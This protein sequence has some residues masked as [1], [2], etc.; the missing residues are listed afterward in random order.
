[1]GEVYRARDPRLER[2]VALKVILGDAEPSL[3]QRRRLEDEA[4]AASA[5]SHP[6]ILSVF[7]VLFDREPPCVVFELLE[8]E[9]LRQRLGPGPLPWRR[10][11]EY[12]T[13]IGQGLAAAHAK[14]I[15]HRD[16]KPENLFVTRDGRVKILDF[17]LAK[18]TQVL[19]HGRNE[20]SENPTRTATQP[21]TLLGTLAYMSPEQARG[22][23][24]DA[25]S[26]IFAL[27]ATLYEMLSGRSAFHRPSAAETLSAVLG[28]DPESLAPPSAVGAVPLG[29]EQIVRRCLEKEPDERFQSARDVSFALS[30]LFASARSDES[31]TAMAP[32]HKRS[33]RPFW[34]AV[35]ALGTLGAAL[36]LGR[37]PRESAG[38]SF[39]RLTFR[40]GDVRT[41][42]F[43]ADGQTIVYGASWDGEPFRLFT[44]RVEQIESRPLDLPA[45]DVL[46]I[47]PQ[48][49]MA[50][51]IGRTR[52]APFVSAGTLARV[53]LA[54]GAPREILE[55]V[56]GADWTPDGRELAVLHRFGGRTRLE[57]P[58]KK[59]LHEGW[60]LGVRVSPRGDVLALRDPEGV[61]LV[62]RDGK[63]RFLAPD[64]GGL[65]ISVAWSPHGDAVW[66]TA[67]EQGTD[68]ELRSVDL[69]GR[70]LRR[71]GLPLFAEVVDVNREGRALVIAGEL[72][73]GIAALPPGEARERDLSWLN[74]SR[75][76]DLS[77]DGRTLL[78]G[79]MGAGR[80]S[81]IYLRRTDGSPAVRLGDGAPAALSPDSKWVLTFTEGT[82][83]E[84]RIIPSGAGESRTRRF[85]E[86]E[87]CGSGRF[88][89]S[90]ER[91]LVDAHA[92][93]EAC[94]AYVVDLEP[95]IP[96]RSLTPPGLTGDAISP[97]GSWV[98]TRGPEGRIRLFPVAGGAP[99]VV[100][101]PPE[102]G[103]IG[104]FSADGRALYVTE[105]PGPVARIFRRDLETGHREI[106]KELSPADP[107]GLFDLSP[108]A[109]AD[110]RS[111]VY[112]HTGFRGSLY[113]LDGLD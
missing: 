3:E 104:P 100:P 48:S 19:G 62:D 109:A 80:K 1:M 59:V 26:D 98:A 79:E 113:L 36:L 75:A 55:D 42:R 14:G 27:G 32:P 5:L 107:A 73:T 91:L 30:A 41:A 61:W 96:P 78:F 87:A 25:R 21:G 103:R 47:S 7:D 22:G 51:C 56:M 57:F 101:G 4:R 81:A 31:A 17:G 46:A 45:G 84:L 50:I 12:A 39:H 52:A 99:R 94:R 89:P 85:E 82:P 9:T 93:G 102:P 108:I 11:V 105:V 38:L 6:N 74:V 28:H 16:L 58:I 110:G 70:I 90:G 34:L 20:T 13:Q 97:D 40:R 77:P 10:A 8:G 95:G 49:E 76:V 29:L 37:A 72:R 112:T 66:Y 69:N 53:P 24:A 35:A 15:V 86:L 67:S 88:F 65:G 111:Y 68:V 106:W 18:T 63:K 43:A 23:K 2:D 60:L 92:G 54:G 71:V 44:T 64:P 83:M 33:A